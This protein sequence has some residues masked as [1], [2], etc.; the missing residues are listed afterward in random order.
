M[1]KRVTKKEEEILDEEIEDELDDDIEESKEFDDSEY[2]ITKKKPLLQKEEREKVA[3]ARGKVKPHCIRCHRTEL[4]KF[5]K[6]SNPFHTSGY[7]PYCKD[8]IGYIFNEFYEKYSEHMETATYVMCR[9]A[10]IPFK[11]KVMEYAN[12]FVLEKGLPETDTYIHYIKYL[13]NTVRMYDNATMTFCDS[14]LSVEAL[15]ITAVEKTEL[16]K[17]IEE[18]KS[19]EEV[20]RALELKELRQRFGSNYTESQLWWLK[21][22]YESWDMGN[23]LNTVALRKSAEIICML[24]LNI[25]DKL[26]KGE[27]A[28]SELSALK[29]QL[30][31]TGL[32]PSANVGIDDRK[33]IGMSIKKIEE[34]KPADE[35][36]LKTRFKDLDKFEEMYRLYY[37]APLKKSLGRE[38][39]DTIDMDK[40]VQ[41]YKIDEDEFVNSGIINDLDD[42]E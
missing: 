17:K 15:K 22:E 14:D 3:R 16:E 36:S 6:S 29:S 39:S 38:D 10:D 8:C 28:S 41:Q 21:N 37:V 31:L 26:S 11:Y 33:T 2:D 20:K 1:A 19:D 18:W 42:G 5:Y 12:K 40:E 34:T 24:N 7:L 23:N 25:K 13:N 30:D 32:K 4:G 27:A 35:I 9:T